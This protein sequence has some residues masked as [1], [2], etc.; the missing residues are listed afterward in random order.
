[1]PVIPG[2]RHDLFVSYAHADNFDSLDGTK[3][4]TRLY[5]SLRAVLRQRL[6]TREEE[7]SV[8]F[9][10]QNR[11][12]DQLGDMLDAASNSALLLIVGS[13]SW[14]GSDFCPQE[15]AA[16]HGSRGDLR[17]IFVAEHLPLL[18][19]DTYPAPITDHVRFRFHRAVSE[20]SST[21][22]P[23]TPE[24]DSRLYRD[25]IYSL[26]EQI[27]E[28]LV[29]LRETGVTKASAPAVAASASTP[30]RV[31]V[32]SGNI[33]LPK[34]AKRALIAEPTD[35]LEDEV[36]QVRAHLEQ[37]D[38]HVLPVAS[39]YDGMDQ[40]LNEYNAALGQASMMIQL[41]G[42]HV[43]RKPPA[44]PTG[45]ARHQYDAA[46]AAGVPV[47]QWRNPELQL[48]PVPDDHREL[49]ETEH[50]I[51]S[52]LSEFK[53]RLVDALQPE[54]EPE[55]A[56]VALEAGQFLFV[57]ADDRD[58]E[59]IDRVLDELEDTGLLCMGPEPE[60]TDAKARLADLEQNFTS[61]DAL[62][63]LHGNAPSTWVKSQLVLFTKLSA[64]RNEKLKLMAICKGPPG[65]KEDIK[66]RLANAQVIDCGEN[67]DMTDV[68]KLVSSLSA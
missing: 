12:N 5:N 47:M 48:D 45:K 63:L 68:R 32:A 23:M 6:G 39:S 37:Y 27:V 38:I 14:A 17:N 10:S 21:R 40:F 52:T 34:G 55:P 1:M 50:V 24:D 64:K 42:P 58:R 67:W 66:F 7:L 54:P 59:A 51:C 61:C 22:I 19:G 35:D 25:R 11:A 49:L 20:E 9:D 31:M 43:G 15:L 30:S 3:D 2:C 29:Q 16:F 13:P 62:I 26:A 53:A 33:D 28:R 4:I 65:P 36:A 57:D 8:F 46:I 56:Q 41:V 44:M 18:P 60:S